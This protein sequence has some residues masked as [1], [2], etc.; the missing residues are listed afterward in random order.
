MAALKTI[1]NSAA[2]LGQSLMAAGAALGWLGR[3][4]MREARQTPN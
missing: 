1:V 2:A 3:R 4:R